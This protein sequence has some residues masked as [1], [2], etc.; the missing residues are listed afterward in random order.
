MNLIKGEDINVMV[1]EGNEML[2]SY[3][4]GVKKNYLAVV[5]LKRSMANDFVFHRFIIGQYDAT[6]STTKTTMEQMKLFSHYYYRIIAMI[7]IIN[8][9][10][11][12]NHLI[13]SFQFGFHRNMIS[14][15]RRF[16]VENGNIGDGKTLIRNA[17]DV[18]KFK[19]FTEVFRSSG[20]TAKEIGDI[21]KV[22]PEIFWKNSVEEID[23]KLVQIRTNLMDWSDPS[24]RLHPTF[25]S[26]LL[27]DLLLVP[28]HRYPDLLSQLDE[29]NQ[30]TGI[31][32]ADSLIEDIDASVDFRASGLTEDGELGQEIDP[33]VLL[34]R[35]REGKSITGEDDNVGGEG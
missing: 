5:L 29:E 22:S 16:M 3:C 34:R 1:P 14:E 15:N 24:Y 18:E 21:L 28:L 10:L 17:D 27:P 30:K 20:F 8:H 23:M 9:I 31:S 33:A 35:L 2:L 11:I 25:M 7:L 26:E 32:R 19:K 6:K 12:S 13:S 4:S